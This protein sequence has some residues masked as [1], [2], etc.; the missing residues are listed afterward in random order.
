MNIEKIA[1][2]GFRNYDWES[3]SF[4]DNINVIFGEN[5]QGKTNLLEAVYILSCG[6]SF[7][8]RTDREMIGFSFSEAE[9]LADVFSHER[10]QT[11]RIRLCPG[12]AKKITVN[13]VKKNISELS[14]TLNVVLFCPDALTV[15]R[16]CLAE[17][18]EFHSNHRRFSCH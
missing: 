14:E 2:N 18:M 10:E 4:E 8:T 3:T 7:R 13:G 9:I 1:L 5:A 6:K 15:L 12:Q 17:G 11:I 16:Y